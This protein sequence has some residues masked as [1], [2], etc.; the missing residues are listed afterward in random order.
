MNRVHDLGHAV[1]A[2]FAGQK[3]D[4]DPGQ[5]CAHHRDQRDQP[6][7]CAAGDIVHHPFHEV[8]CLHEGQRDKGGERSDRRR[9]QDEIPV[10]LEAELRAEAAQSSRDRAVHRTKSAWTGHEK[11]FSV[12]RWPSRSR[13]AVVLVVF[14]QVF[15]EE[16]DRQLLH[17]TMR[18]P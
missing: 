4:G 9:Q 16:I 10:P 6:P 8:D 15:A 7:Q 17:L 14:A 18:F 13:S 5:Q 3:M 12:S 1:P 11:L 2:R